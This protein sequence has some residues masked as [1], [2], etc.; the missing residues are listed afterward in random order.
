MNE[1]IVFF[2]NYGLPMTAIAILGIAILGI[3]KYCNLFSGLNE[4]YRH[5]FYIGISV[6]I[7]I[8]GTAIYLAAI[9]QFEFNYIITVSSALFALNQAFYSIFKATSINDLG[10]RLLDIFCELWNKIK[11][12]NNKNSE[13]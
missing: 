1:L 13:E 9:N 6:T 12:K 8:I 4:K 2:E 10:T 3:L 5:W 7:S 11:N